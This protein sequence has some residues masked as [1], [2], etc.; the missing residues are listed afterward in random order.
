MHTI[1]VEPFW[2]VIDTALATEMYE[3]R[4]VTYKRANSP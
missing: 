4:T 3:L 1:G 2:F